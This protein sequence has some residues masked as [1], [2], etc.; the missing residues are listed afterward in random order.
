LN[1]P[2]VLGGEI[3]LKKKTAMRTHRLNRRG[4]EEKVT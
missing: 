3:L 1:K 4:I 2:G